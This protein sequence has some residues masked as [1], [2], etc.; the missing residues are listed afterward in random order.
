MMWVPETVPVQRMNARPPASLPGV[1][2]VPFWMTNW[3]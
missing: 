1:T 2:W 3:E